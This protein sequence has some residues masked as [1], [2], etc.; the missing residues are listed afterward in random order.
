MWTPQDNPHLE[1]EIG[2]VIAIFAFHTKILGIFENIF[3][4]QLSPSFKS[5]VQSLDQSGTLKCLLTTTNK[6]F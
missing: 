2:R 3:F 1:L 4:V 5:Q 6:I